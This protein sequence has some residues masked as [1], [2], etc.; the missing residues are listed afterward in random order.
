MIKLVRQNFQKESSRGVSPDMDHFWNSMV[1]KCMRDSGIYER[2]V[3][4]VVWVGDS[5]RILKV[6]VMIQEFFIVEE[7]CESTNL[8]EAVD[9]G[10]A[11]QTAILKDMDFS[12]VLDLLLLEVAPLT[13]K[14]LGAALQ[15]EFA[16]EYSGPRHSPSRQSPRQSLVRQSPRQSPLWQS[17]T[18]SVCRGRGRALR[19]RA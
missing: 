5:A 12:Q 14:T 1:G 9:F 13:M 3:L 18:A 4:E 7:L 19:G 17:R 2:N 6:Q 11:V 15:Q 8:D 10:A 16:H